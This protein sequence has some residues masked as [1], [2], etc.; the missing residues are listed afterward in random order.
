M[1]PSAAHL[2]WRARSSS[3]ALCFSLKKDVITPADDWMQLVVG[4]FVGRISNCDSINWSS[5]SFSCVRDELTVMSEAL[6]EVEAWGIIIVEG[7]GVCYVCGDEGCVLV[8]WCF[9][10]R[11]AFM[12]SCVGWHW[13]HRTNFERGWVGWCYCLWSCGLV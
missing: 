8:D 2:V 12:F 10:V 9:C 11:V 1:R 6:G 13:R 3:H 4:I 5:G 7:G